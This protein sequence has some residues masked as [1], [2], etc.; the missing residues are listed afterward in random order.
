MRRFGVSERADVAC[1]GMTVAQAATLGVLLAEPGL[2][3]SDLGRRLGITPSTLSRNLARLLEERPRRAHGD[4]PE[5]ARA[6]RVQPD[7]GG[8]TQGRGAARARRRPLP[9]TC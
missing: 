1:C 7:R 4:D 2:R 9:T 5:D 3:L 8:T 6:A